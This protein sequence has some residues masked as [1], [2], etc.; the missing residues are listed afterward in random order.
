[1]KKVLLSLC[2]FLL[3]GVAAVAQKSVYIPQQMREEGYDAS[4]TNNNLNSKWSRYRSR[5]SDNIIVFWENGFGNNDPNSSAVEEAYRVDVD[6]MLQKLETFYALNVNTL[7]FADL[8]NS[9]LSQY[10][11]VICL[12]Y[13]TDWMAYGSGFDNLI[14]GMW[15]SPS[16][17]H[18]VGS[19]IAHE[20]G[21]S[22]QYQCFCDLGGNTGFRYATGQG[23]A[24]WEGTANWQAA[25][26]YPDIMYTQ[27]MELYSKAHNTAMTHEWMRYQSYWMYYWWV[28]QNNQKIV[29][30]IWRSGQNEGEDPN[31]VYMRLKGWDVNTLYKDYMDAAMHFV[32]WDFNDAAWKNRG[33][34]FVGNF[35]FNAI[36]LGDNEFQVAY[37]SCPQATGYNVIAL[38][39]PEAGTTLTTTFTALAPG[40][41][42]HDDDPR[43]YWDGG[44]VATA[45]TNTYNSFTGSN[46]RGFRLGY[47]ALKADGTRLYQAADQVYCTGTAET[48]VD[49][50][51]TVPAGVEKLWLVVSPAPTQYFRHLWNDTPT[52]DDQW[53]YKVKFTNTSLDEQQ[54]VQKLDGRSIADVRFTYDVT[55]PPDANG[56]TAA[57]IPLSS[58]AQN[59]LCTAF[60]LDATALNNAFATATTSGPA[61]GQIMGFPFGAN[62]AV[63]Y[64]GNTANGTFGHWFDAAGNVTAWGNNSYVFSEYYS[65]GRSFTVG[66]YPGSNADGTTR[67]IRQAMVYK[68]GNGETATAYFTFN[69]TFKAGATAAGKLTHIDYDGTGGAGTTTGDETWP[70]ISALPNDYSKYFFTFR[71]HYKNLFLTLRDGEH[72]ND[73]AFDEKTMWYS[74]QTADRPENN[75]RSLWTLDAYGD[76]YQLITCADYR[77]YFLQNEWQGAWYCRTHDNGGGNFDWGR[78]KVAFDGSVATIQNGHYGG[79]NYLGPWDNAFVDGA[80]VAF[81]KSGGTTGFFDISTILRGAYVA[82][83]ENHHEAT[84][85]HPLDITYVLENEG[86]ERLTTIGW[87][88]EGSEWAT[89][90]NSELAGKAGNRYF[91]IAVNGSTSTLYQDIYGLPAGYYRFSAVATGNGQG[92]SLALIANRQ[93]EAAPA[94]NQ[95]TRCAVIVQLSEGE[96]LRVGA[97]ALGTSSDWVAFDEARL[98]YVGTEIPSIR[99]GT[100][101][102]NVT[103]GVYLQQFDTW[104]LNFTEATGEASG[105]TFAK[106]NSNA[107]AQ[108]YKA[109]RLAGEYDILVS[110]TT[111]SATFTGL[112]LDA[113]TD[114]RLELPAGA[115][116]YAGQVAN[117]AV[118]ITFHTPALFDGTYYLYNTYTHNYLSR[119]GEWATAAILDDWGLAL[120][121]TTDGQNRTTLKY[122]DSQV[123]LYNDGFCYADGETGLSFNVTAVS[124]GYKFLNLNNN[125]Y[126]A[127]FG[128]RSVADAAEGDNLD[129]T[130][131]VWA[132]ETTTEHVANYTRC[133]D[134]QAAAA[135]TTAGIAGVS[136]FAAMESLMASAYDAL[137]VAVTGA[138]RETFIGYAATAQENTP[139][140]Y[141][142]ETVTGLVPGLY[143]LSADAF[144]RACWFEDVYAADGARG[145]IY[146]YAGDAKTQLKSVMEYGAPTAYDSDFER[147]GLH[148]PNNESCGREALQTGNYRN[149]VYVYVPADEGSETGT[150]TIGISNPNRMGN[151]IERATWAIYRNFQLERLIPVVALSDADTS[152]PTPAN[153]VTMQLTRTL[154]GGQWNGFSVPFAFDIEGSA[155]QGASVRKFGSSDGNELSFAEETT[156]IEA[157]EPYLVKP[158]SDI[159]NPRFRDVNLTCPDEAVHG[160]GDYKF[161]ARLYYTYL[162]TDGSVAYVSTTDSSVKKLTSGHLKGLRSYFQIPTSRN[163]KALVLRLDGNTTAIDD[164]DSNATEGDTYNVVGQRVKHARK[165]VFIVNGKKVIVK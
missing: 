11:M 51:Y 122:F 163:A 141:F 65:N 130:S 66:Q 157:G 3:T 46:A 120:I 144:Q 137:P 67:T 71:D 22:F 72:Q 19:T 123:Y 147:D 34:A 121:A 40:S 7:G 154:K 25:Q 59:A 133:A 60:Q 23:S 87:K 9:K 139:A 126:L 29:G 13:T 57:S 98:E 6:D 138:D 94:E 24:W 165:G 101:A 15:V 164:I 113:A 142:K 151:G 136:T 36:P 90:D 160:D 106:L 80:E 55:L 105:M 95:G 119:G 53:P 44:K 116:G 48:S 30:Q 77:N 26:A 32:T 18:P 82:Q 12:Y 107:K 33:S 124:G 78:A 58:G 129:G 88:C 56:Y 16:T 4:T 110:G 156:A 148:Y 2:A 41:R 31:E 158:T 93:Q 35:V 134:N 152:A 104:T 75:K 47:V 45:N 140:E 49:V 102:S 52:D 115:V 68:N 85:T 73:D 69:I 5:E 21:H 108:L 100:P 27:S 109:N 70:A 99:I 54:F 50:S 39:V 146:L 111:V 91:R 162:P 62:G 159:A 131:N 128:G 132:V 145:C 135:A 155:L 125:R 161:A 81:N 64:Q 8:S 150:L 118:S 86:A 84:F 1:M 17:C 92:N 74:S 143:R 14:G 96:T 149:V 117:E 103:D 10:K 153:H 42:L 89:S 83:Y 43:E 37:Y 38:Q 20:I 79:E 63:T 112:T 61:N 76:G 114:Y 97:K 127:H 28:Q